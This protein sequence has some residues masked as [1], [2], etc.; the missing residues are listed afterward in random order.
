MTLTL[1]GIGAAL[2]R[3]LHDAVPALLVL[4]L[5]R[6]VGE[7]FS[8]ERFSIGFLVAVRR[9]GLHARAMLGPRVPGDGTLYDGWPRAGHPRQLKERS[10]GAGGSLSGRVASNYSSPA[11]PMSIDLTVILPVLDERDNVAA[12]P[13]RLHP[14]LAALGCTSEVLVVDGGSRDGTADLAGRLGARVLVQCAPGYGCALGEGFAAARGE[15]VLT[16][17]S[18]LSHDPD[19]IGKLW[20]AR[21]TAD[22]V[23]AS[24]YVKEGVAYMQF[25]R[26]LLSV[27]LNRFFA[28]GLSLPVRDLSSGFRLYRASL[29]GGLRSDCAAAT[30]TCSRRF[31]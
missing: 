27:V 4:V 23:I 12:L 9:R 17:D 30:S 20:R 25:H 16:L 24:R 10:R 7:A 19:F 31:S 28:R 15:F 1:T 26:A 2:R 22:V 11:S 6:V 18:D 3:P 5:R 29:L 8:E 13:P 21:E 14:V